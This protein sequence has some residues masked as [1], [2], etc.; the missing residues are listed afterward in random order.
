MTAATRNAAVKPSATLIAMTKRRGTAS[1]WRVAGVNPSTP[2]RFAPAG[3]ERP[4]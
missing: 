4:G 1:V 3:T 2:L